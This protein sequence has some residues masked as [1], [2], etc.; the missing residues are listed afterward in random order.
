MKCEVIDYKMTIDGERNENVEAKQIRQS[1]EFF[2]VFFFSN[3]KE[4]NDVSIIS[5]DMSNFHTNIYMSI[6]MEL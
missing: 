4:Y 1:V 3:G 6:C 2:K 5:Y